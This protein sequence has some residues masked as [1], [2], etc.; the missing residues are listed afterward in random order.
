MAERLHIGWVTQTGTMIVEV[1]D[2]YKS[3]EIAATRA[4]KEAFS[5]ELRCPVPVYI[6]TVDGSHVCI[7]Q[8]DHFVVLTEEDVQNMQ[9]MMNPEEAQ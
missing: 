6:E 4:M 8:V 1:A 2:T 7:M 3:E 9:K 5:E